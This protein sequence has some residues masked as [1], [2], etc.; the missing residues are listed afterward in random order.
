MSCAIQ[1]VP[2]RPEYVDAACEIAVRAWE[3]IHVSAIE[4]L[5]EEMHEALFSDW[6]ERKSDDVR[7]MLAGERAFVALMDG[8]V[9]G[10]IGYRVN[11]AKKLGQISLNAVD[12][13]MRG[14]GI[15]PQMYDFVL[16]KMREEGMLY[17]T[18]HTGLDDGHAPAR[19]AYAKAGFKRGRPSVDYY[20]EL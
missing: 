20:R 10:F 3:G 12:P 19:R 1:I 11:P 13:A 4:D 18:V 6:R 17:A 15:A 9:V 14:K 16:N 8:K 7:R 2:C 5:G